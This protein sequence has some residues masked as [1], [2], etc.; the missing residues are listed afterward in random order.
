M[1]TN[2][3]SFVKIKVIGVGGAGGN[4]INDMISSGVTGV[5][6]IAANTDAQDLANSL[7]DIRIQLGP[8][9]TKGLG[10]GANP[11][12]GRLS[13]EEDTEQIKEV[14]KDTDMLFVTAG[15]GGGT[16]T[17][18]APVIAGIAKEMGILTIGIG[19]RPFTFEGNKR[20]TNADNG[21]MALRSN[22]DTLVMIP[23]DKLFELPQKTITLK[24]AF[25]AANEV[26]K[27][28]VK[29]VSELITRH[30]F[31]NLD[32][33]DIKT[34]MANSGVAM[35]GFGEASGEGRALSATEQALSNP[36]LEKSIEGAKRILINITG[37]EDFGLAEAY[38]ISNAVRSAAGNADADDIMFGTVIDSDMDNTVK[39]TIVA[40]DFNEYEE[41]KER[42]EKTR[43]EDQMKTKIKEIS[44]TTT[45]EVSDV[46]ELDV[47]A[48]IRRKKM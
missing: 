1:F 4:A 29:G 33:A 32:F 25:E 6:F 22:V 45:T 5:E 9:L 10:A 42:E 18:A 44:N 47:P 15:M 17:G 27:I 14:L 28:G 26:L 7:A 36:L 11:E 2:T 13:V 20:K 39:V 34:T 3:E 12:I 37:G 23:N 41:I 19:T 16:G 46:D 30:G 43:V 40:T 35:L 38:E 48:F 8:E 31:I 21:V 24:N